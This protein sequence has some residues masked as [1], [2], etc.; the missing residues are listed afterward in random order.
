MTTLSRSLAALPE[1]SWAHPLMGNRVPG[2]EESPM[3]NPMIHRLCRY[4]ETERATTRT[5][6]ARHDACIVR[7]SRMDCSRRFAL[8][9]PSHTGG[10][11]RCYA[12][13]ECCARV[14]GRGHDPHVP[15]CCSL[16]ARTPYE[17][18]SLDSRQVGRQ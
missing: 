10:L 13:G 18:A 2:V 12:Q 4:G 8:A 6:N 11:L 9:I 17:S 14:P 15:L 16:T 7:R 3:Y 5:E 1:R